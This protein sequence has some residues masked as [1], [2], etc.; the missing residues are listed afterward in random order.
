MSTGSASTG[1]VSTGGAACVKGDVIVEVGN[2]TLSFGGVTSLSDVSLNQRRGEILSVIGPNGAG[3]TSLFN[4][5][6]G[7][8]KPQH[9]W[10]VF[11][12]ANGHKT[13]VVGRKPHQVNHAGIA[14]TFQ[15]S[16]LF[17]ALTTF[18]NV[19]IGVE[20]RQHTGPVGAMLHLPRARREE[21]Q[22]DARVLELLD[23]VGLRQRANDL[24]SSLPYGDRRRLEIA[25]ALGT[26]PQLV[27]L[28]EPAAGTNPSEKIELAR[29]IR[30]VNSELGVSV[31]LIEHDMGLVMSIAERVIVLSFGKI[32]AAGTPAEVQRDP[33]VI[34]AY[35]G[36]S[37]QRKRPADE[38]DE[39]ATAG[40]PNG[41]DNPL[42]SKAGGPTIGDT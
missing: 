7:V 37:R 6:T 10:V 21:R 3:K 40:S 14:R 36:T 24:A 25:R 41:T 30:R 31:L 35:L 28:D 22:S 19:K 4:C 1:P 15:T 11:H 8:Y 13:M 39:G 16:R 42:S 9:G 38:G 29:V 32:I 18:E 2:V 26:R 12:S 27:L 5:L 33:A 23:F 17:N 34:E 20:S